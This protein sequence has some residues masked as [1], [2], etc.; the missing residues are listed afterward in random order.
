M[1]NRERKK[2]RQTDRQRKRDTNRQTEKEK[3]MYHYSPNN[4]INTII[5]GL[6]VT[7]WPNKLE[8]LPL[9]SLSSVLQ[10]NDLAYLAHS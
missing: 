5:W 8:C 10:W 6:Y 1:R 9:A 4:F 7:N 2:D 3:K